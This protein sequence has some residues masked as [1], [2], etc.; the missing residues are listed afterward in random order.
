MVGWLSHTREVYVGGGGGTTRI[1]HHLHNI[2]NDTCRRKMARSEMEVVVAYLVDDLVL[3]IL[4]A[5]Y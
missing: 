1:G 5:W 4:S 2:W 3:T